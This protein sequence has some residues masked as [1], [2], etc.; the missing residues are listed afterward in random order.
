M[1]KLSDYNSPKSSPFCY[2]LLKARITVSY[3]KS[4]LKLLLKVC[5]RIIMGIITEFHITVS[6]ALL[7]YILKQLLFTKICDL[8]GI[9]CKRD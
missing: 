6:D 7:C 5:M 2:I 3:Q 4:F 8:L 1:V 9:G